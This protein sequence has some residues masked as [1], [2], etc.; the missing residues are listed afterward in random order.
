M[1]DA[2]SLRQ[3]LETVI[4]ALQTRGYTFPR[5]HYQTL[6]NERKT[7]QVDSEQLAAKRK[8]L[9]Q[10]IGQKKAKGENS[11][12]LMQQVSAL[13]D[14]QSQIDTKLQTIQTQLDDLLTSLPNLPAPTTPIGKD[15]SDNIEI[16]R[17]GTPRD[18]DFP[19]K[20]HADLEQIGLD[21]TT[22]SKLSGA[23]F[24]VLHHHLARL[25]RP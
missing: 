5:E 9:S 12:D 22:A 21:F 8:T 23:R 20:E 17:V 19:V 11:D 2:K 25:H 15:E 13:S 24:V 3:D 6:E 14:S 18:Y 7:L 16:R 10:E 4:N 1:I